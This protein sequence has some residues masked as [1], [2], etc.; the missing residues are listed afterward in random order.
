MAPQ[1]ARRRC[2][3]RL[4]CS[5]LHQN[6]LL[7]AWNDVVAT[8]V[9]GPD[10]SLHYFD[11]ASVQCEDA[12]TLNLWAWSADPSKIPKVQLVTFTCNQLP[13][14]SSSAPLA[15]RQGLRRRIPVHLDQIEDFLPDVDGTIPR[16]PNPHAPFH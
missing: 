16:R 11:I 4:P 6:V 7:N 5:P 13:A 2:A 3:R 14:S 8:Q 15:G 12:A 9:L 1:H 10:T